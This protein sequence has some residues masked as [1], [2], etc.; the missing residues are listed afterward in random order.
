VQWL[1]ARF[2]LR[3]FLLP[4]WFYPLWVL[5]VEVSFPIWFY[6]LWLLLLVLV[7]LAGVV[8]LAKCCFIFLAG[9][10]Q[11]LLQP[12]KQYAAVVAEWLIP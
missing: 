4:F 3:S 12:C 2:P 8:A 7:A 9:L 6:P 10:G 5:L 11:A 1:T